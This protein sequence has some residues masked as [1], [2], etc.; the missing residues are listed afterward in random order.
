VEV[1]D[2]PRRAGIH[3]PR[4]ENALSAKRGFRIKSGMTLLEGRSSFNNLAKRPA[5]GRGWMGE[6]Q[7]AMK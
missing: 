7:R 4:V 6:R 1:D 3:A 5:Q 2:T